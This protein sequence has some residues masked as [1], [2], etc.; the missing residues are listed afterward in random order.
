[1]LVFKAVSKCDFK[2]GFRRRMPVRSKVLRALFYPI[3]YA[4][5]IRLASS[6]ISLFLEISRYVMPRLCWMLRANSSKPWSLK[7][8]LDMSKKTKVVLNLKNRENYII[9]SLL[10]LLPPKLSSCSVLFSAK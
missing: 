3:P 8:F 6:D 10:I 5:V 1:M 2:N 9:P 7:S 4:M